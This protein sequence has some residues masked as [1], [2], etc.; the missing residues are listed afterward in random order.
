MKSTLAILVAAS[1][2]CLGFTKD[3]TTYTTDGSQS[4]V[5]AAIADASAGDTVNVPSG[6]FTWGASGNPVDVNKAITLSGAGTNSTTINI[7]ATGPTWGGGTIA[8]SAAAVVK[9]FKTAQPGSANTTAFAAGSVDGWRITDI[10]H[11]SAST[12]GYFVYAATYGLIDN[13]TVVG[14]SGNDELIFTRGPTNSWQTATSLGTTNAVYIEDCVF[15]N[16][17][18]VSDFNSN[19]RGVARFCTINGTLK[20]DGHGKASNTPA[21]GVRS[22]EA[23]GNIWTSA[24]AYYTTIE[25][26]GGTGVI[27]DNSLPNAAG[28]NTW[29]SLRE[30]GLTGAYANFGSVYM[31]PA[32]YPVDDQIGVGQDPKS[33]GSE[34][35][36]IWNN[37]SSTGDWPLNTFH[38]LTAAIA[39][40]GS[41]FTVADI[42]AADRDYFKHTVGGTFDG[43][44]GVGRGTAAQMSAITPT[45][46][47]V[48]FW[49]T[50]E[51]EWNSEQEGVDGRLY[52]WNGSAWVLKYTPLTY[53]H[54]LRGGPPPPV[55]S[56]RQAR[57]ASVNVGTLIVQ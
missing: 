6:E 10:H 9:S 3:G 37:S 7:S 29:L 25:F 1:L 49:V 45:L 43:T 32:D 53:P 51:G 17:G 23:Y 2:S 48:G 52:T 18:Y 21:R 55:I 36:Y 11:L 8:I 34:P 13:C 15:E 28:A 19:A 44:S 30:Y 24:G 46:T 38:N 22:L 16:Q 56:G 12:V 27:F 47:G 39:Q 20:I 57:A 41:D 33:A 54:P 50:D 31:T 35:L 4:D 42:I 40:Y 5:E 14:G 26:R